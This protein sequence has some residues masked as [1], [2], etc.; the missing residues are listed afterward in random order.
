MK[1]TK[2]SM[3]SG[4]INTMEIPV[5]M[6]QMND[7]LSGKLIQEAMPNINA[8]QREFIMTG[9]TPE[10]QKLMFDLPP[11]KWPAI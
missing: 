4:T 2:I 8:E 3:F 10:E 11:D 7:W 9:V 1:I 5:T 6:S